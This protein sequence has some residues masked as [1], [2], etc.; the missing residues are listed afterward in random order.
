MS[1]KIE[2]K[3]PDIAALIK[4]NQDEINRFI[5]AQMQFNRGMLFDN[6]GAYNGHPKWAP[7]AFRSGQILTQRGVLRKSIAPYA[8]NGSAGTDGY[9][10]RTNDTVTIGTNLFYAAMV[11][12]GTKNLP[13]GVLKPKNA[14]ALKIPIP[15]GANA[16]GGAKNIQKEAIS[17]QYAKLA[18][19]EIK[20]KKQAEAWQKQMFRLREKMHN[21]EKGKG[22]VNFIFVKSVKIPE[23]R[24]DQWNDEDQLEMSEALC[25]KL[26]DIISKGY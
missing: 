5:A 23:R 2:L 1:V 7:L 26:A 22:P 18:K 9:V 4:R 11:N 19:K 16:G 14:K 10:R 20:T 15:K 12:F 6:E 21:A 24:F 13:G 17:K 8:A 25:N 3:F